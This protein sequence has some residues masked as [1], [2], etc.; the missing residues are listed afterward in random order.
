[1]NKLVELLNSEKTIVLEILNLVKLADQISA[2]GFEKT[3][4]YEAK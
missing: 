1:M 2:Y 4:R 3:D